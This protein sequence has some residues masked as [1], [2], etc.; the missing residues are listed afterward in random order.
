MLRFD[1]SLLRRGAVLAG[2]SCV[3]AL[4]VASFAPPGHAAGFLRGDANADGRLDISDAVAMLQQLF[5]ERPVSCMEAADADG[6]RTLNVTDPIYLLAFL[7]R[8]APSPPAPFPICASPAGELALGCAEP[9]CAF[10]GEPVWMGR[11]DGCRQCQA[12]CPPIDEIVEQL[13][14]DGIDVLDATVGAVPVCLACDV[15]PSGRFY[16]VLV[17]P[18]DANRLAPAGWGPFDPGGLLPRR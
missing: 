8:A 9:Q 3:L 11:A 2:A 14:A 10:D 16:V 13:R 6:S 15:C 5:A 18:A 4:F 7:F 1:A 17:P 12:A